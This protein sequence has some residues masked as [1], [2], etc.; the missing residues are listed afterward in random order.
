MPSLSNPDSSQIVQKFWETIR[1]PGH[2]HDV[3]A[4][5]TQRALREI[6]PEPGVWFGRWWCGNTWVTLHLRRSGDSSSCSRFVE[7]EQDTC[8]AAI[9][10]DIPQGCRDFKACSLRQGGGGDD[11]KCSWGNHVGPRVKRMALPTSDE[12]MIAIPVPSG[13]KQVKQ[14]FSH[15]VLNQSDFC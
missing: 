5:E 12:F 1:E 14:V 13:I 3:I 15:H 6:C 4:M 8:G 2:D 10:N 9:G 11:L 7:S